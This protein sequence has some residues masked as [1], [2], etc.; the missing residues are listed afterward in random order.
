MSL[1][2]DP[3]LQA[4]FFL[5]AQKDLASSPRERKGSMEGTR[6]YEHTSASGAKMLIILSLWRHWWT[7]TYYKRYP[8]CK[9]NRL[10]HYCRVL[11]FCCCRNSR[12]IVVWCRHSW[13]RCCRRCSCRRR[14]RKRSNRFLEKSESVYD[15]S[16]FHLCRQ[17]EFD[18]GDSILSSNR[19]SM[20]AQQP[21]KISLAL[22]VVKVV[23]L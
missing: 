6:I 9:P 13:Q 15:Y 21:L 23:Y 14:W 8:F 4:L 2:D 3:L 16:V 1:M 7:T 11:P 17:A 10:E 22:Q 12:Q 18:Y 20:L 5:Q 19:F